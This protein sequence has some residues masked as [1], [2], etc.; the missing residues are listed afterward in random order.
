MIKNISKMQSVIELQATIH[1]IGIA[2]F[3]GRINSGLIPNDEGYA[4][5]ES[6]VEEAKQRPILSK[7]TKFVLNSN[8]SYIQR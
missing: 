3:V 8:D 1:Q 7:V 6:F 2:R 4:V 5:V